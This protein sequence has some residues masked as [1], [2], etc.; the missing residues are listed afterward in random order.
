VLWRVRQDSSIHATPALDV[1]NGR[2][3]V[4]TEQWN[5]GSP[6]GS[7]LALDWSTGRLLWRHRHRYWA[8]G[9][10]CYS[11]EHQAVVATCNDATM[12]CVDAASGD[13]RWELGT[14]GL[15]RGRP[16]VSRGRAY[17][18]TE[19][20][21]LHC[22]DMHSGKERWT[23]RYGAGVMHL[24][25]VAR[26]GCIFLFDRRWHLSAFDE[27]SGALRWVSRLRSAGV[28]CPVACGDYM[29][30]LSRGGHL[31]VLDPAR[32]LKVW[33]GSIDG[34]YRQ[35]PAIGEGHLAAASND[36]GL[37]VFRIHDFYI[38]PGRNT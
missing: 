26:S 34:H 3:F 22:V 11:A 25:L 1:A 20:G 29:V 21:W 17:A 8:P 28:W 23:V 4:N 18:A 35:P 37:K 32:E 19:K 16:V 24:F 27:E 13:L 15:V 36:Q 7:L 5:S 12:A 2:V 30:A 33:E 6:L 14:R 31:S 38:S 9:S 10:P